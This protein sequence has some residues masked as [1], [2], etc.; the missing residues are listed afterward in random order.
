MLRFPKRY[1]DDHY[2]EDD[3][4]Q[5]LS[6]PSCL[7]GPKFI[8]HLIIVQVNASVV[9]DAVSLMGMMV[10]PMEEEAEEEEDTA[11]DTN[12]AD[13]TIAERPAHVTH[14]REENAR[15]ATLAVTVTAAKV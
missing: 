2:V 13:V 7:I 9:L 15:E 6:L 12:P 1:V 8:S 10:P 14:S 4:V 3:R 11:A 5:N